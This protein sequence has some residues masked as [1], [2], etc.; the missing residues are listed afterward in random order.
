MTACL[1]LQR[2]KV[3]R[4]KK[5]WKEYFLSLQEVKLGTSPIKTLD[6]NTSL[7]ELLTLS[8]INL[9]QPSPQEITTVNFSDELRKH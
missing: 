2:M 4:K 3:L 8:S 1:N 5:F 9:L 6:V 7:E